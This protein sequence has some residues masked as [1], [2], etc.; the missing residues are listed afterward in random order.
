MM[1]LYKGG[2]QNPIELQTQQYHTFC[3]RFKV[4]WLHLHCNITWLCSNPRY[5]CMLGTNM[6]VTF[7]HVLYPGASVSCPVIKEGNLISPHLSTP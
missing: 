7:V 2:N 1:I 6:E 4:T 3:T 5:V